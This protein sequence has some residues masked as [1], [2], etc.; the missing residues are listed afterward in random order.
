MARTLGLIE[1]PTSM[2]AFAPGQEK[3]P[4]AL[5]NADLIG[6]LSRSGV[7]VVECGG[8]ATRTVTHPPTWMRSG[9]RPDHAGDERTSW[10]MSVLT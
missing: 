10:I 4:T 8:T 5:R 6:R 1:I 2:G 3:G 9:V 7:G